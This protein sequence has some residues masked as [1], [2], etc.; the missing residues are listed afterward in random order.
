MVHD[1]FLANFSKTLGKS[2]TFASS[3]LDDVYV[4]GES[5]AAAERDESAQCGP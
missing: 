3:E 2:V 4:K 5:P 1:A